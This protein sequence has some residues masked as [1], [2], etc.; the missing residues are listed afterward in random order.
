MLPALLEIVQI[1]AQIP[2]GYYDEAIG[3]EGYDLKRSL[4]Q[5]IKRNHQNNG[6]N[7]LYS[8]YRQTDTDNYYEK[9]GTL[10]DM[11]SENPAGSDPYNYTHGNRQCGSYSSEGN[12]YNREHLFPQGF[13][14]KQG[15]MKND[16][17]FVVPS[18]GKVNGQ[19]SNYPFGE[20]S[21]ANWTSRNGSK[22]GA[23]SFPGYSGTVFEP[24][25]EFKGDIARCLLYFVTRYA[26][27]LS[28]FNPAHSRNPLDGSF[29]QGYEDW[30]INLLLKW[31]EQDPVS[32]REIDRNNAAQ[33]YQGN[34]NPFIDHPEWVQCIWRNNCGGGAVNNPPVIANVNILPTSPKEGETVK[35][36][37][38]VTDSDGTLQSV[39]LSWGP[40]ENSLNNHIPMQLSGGVYTATI[41][42]QSEGIK[43]FYKITATDNKNG[44]SHSQPAS[45]TVAG[46]TANSAPVI[47]DIQ[48]TPNNPEADDEVKISAKVTDS[49][50]TLQ[51]VFLSWGSAENS[52]NNHIPMQLSGGVYTATIPA[53]SEG[54]KVFYKITATDN[55]NG[56]S[57]SQPASYTV[58]GGTANNA[59]VIAD[60]QQT[61]N[62]PEADDEVKI[63]AKVTDDKAVAQ[64]WLR[65]GTSSGFYPGK[66]KMTKIGDR[67]ETESGIP[68]QMQNLTV[69]YKIFATDNNSLQSQSP[70]QS[71]TVSATSGSHNP[72]VIS[73]VQHEPVNPKVNEKIRVSAKVTD[74]DGTLE[75]VSLFW[76]KEQNTLTNQ[77]PMQLSGGVYSAE[78]PAQNEETSVFYKITARD[79]EGRETRTVEYSFSVLSNSTAINVQNHKES[80]KIFPNP[81]QERLNISGLQ[82]IRSI[83]IINI[84][85][86]VKIEKNI[87]PEIADIQIN[88]NDLPKGVYFISFQE[89][90]G[91]V[92]AIFFVRK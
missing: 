10:L 9:D 2:S 86:Q 43:V 16:I 45:Y 53:Q 20:V 77:I 42:A 48:Q 47:A 92:F 83:R 58:A 34:R 79:N 78:I 87:S 21:S 63:S 70:E 24:I 75:N 6:Y 13:F 60:I 52:L 76:G 61:P 66:I 89:I 31:H 40:A 57:H 8:G 85:G 82:K 55:E 72:P 17:H 26:D 39:S 22:R 27:R 68:Q 56:T 80:I 35:V 25:D 81:V 74:S 4:H 73:D 49:D 54:I 64:V 32:Q 38:Q 88:T 14:N 23:C 44:T 15:P 51:S 29:D 65:W 41:P 90:S 12:C 62:N 18:D 67:Y 46:G 1:F 71:Y 33:D 5:I 50:G 30:Y 91:R 59:P 84:L 37:A 11:Y 19:R 36:S 7:P 3:K 28:S 69:Y